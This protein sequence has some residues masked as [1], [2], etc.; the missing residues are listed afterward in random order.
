MVLTWGPLCRYVIH[1][2]NSWNRLNWK[3]WA[4][5]HETSFSFIFWIPEILSNCVQ[6]VP[7]KSSAWNRFPSDPEARNVKRRPRA[8]WTWWKRPPPLVVWWSWW[9]WI[10]LICMGQSYWGA[11]VRQHDL[12]Y[13][14]G[15]DTGWF[16]EFG[17]LHRWERERER[18][19][20]RQTASQAGR[21]RERVAC[22]NYRMPKNR[23]FHL[24]SKT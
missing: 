16:R 19:T 21:E 5:G 3:T 11:C 7:C 23:N 12:L 2:L 8:F 1:L 10:Y 15:H 22:S 24:Y 20:D 17:C 18:Q 14:R 9:W 13:H 6:T 4:W